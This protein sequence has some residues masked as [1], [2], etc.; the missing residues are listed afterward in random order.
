LETLEDRLNLNGPEILPFF[1]D[2]HSIRKRLTCSK[3]N[4]D[5]F[6]EIPSCGWD[7]YFWG[8]PLHSDNRKE[9]PQIR[10][11]F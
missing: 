7:L 10:S 3:C 6:I 2:I 1:K 9:K 4:L 11:C 5:H 8:P